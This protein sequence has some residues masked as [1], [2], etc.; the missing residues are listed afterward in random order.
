MAAKKARF[1]NKTC[2][3][4]YIKVVNIKNDPT[5]KL[6]IRERQYKNALKTEIVF[7]ESTFTC[8]LKQNTLHAYCDKYKPGVQL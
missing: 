6:K 4:T 7:D 8:G 2:R 3:Q 1:L 5:E